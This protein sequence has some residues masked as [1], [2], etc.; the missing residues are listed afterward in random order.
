MTGRV[1]SIDI[2]QLTTKVVE[3]DF[4]AKEPHI[5]AAFQF[6]T[7]EGMLEDGTIKTDD[8]F[9]NRFREE[10]KERKIRTKRVVFTIPSARIAQREITIPAVKDKK[11]ENVLQANAPEYFPVDLKQYQLIHRIMERDPEKKEI[12]LSVVAVPN[13]LLS[14][15]RSLANACG[16]TIADVDYEGHSIFNCMNMEAQGGFAVSLKVDER[17]SILTIIDQD[18]IAQQRTI[19][20]GLGEIIELLQDSGEFG[21]DLSVEKALKILETKRWIHK[22]LDYRVKTPSFLEKM[23]L[24]GDEIGSKDKQEM[25][26]DEATDSLQ[27]LVSNVARALSYYTSK[28]QNAI[29]TG[30]TLMGVGTRCRGLAELLTSE[31]NVPVRPLTEVKGVT[32]ESF[33]NKGEFDLAL[34]VLPIGSAISPMNLTIGKMSFNG[35]EGN[36]EFAST[37]LAAGFCLVCL[38][39][40]AA[41]CL[42]I[43]IQNRNLINEKETLQAQIDSMQEAKVA[44]DNYMATKAK[45]EDIS[46]LK[47]ITST[48]LDQLLKFISNLENKMPGNV[49]VSVMSATPTE[50]VINV[51]TNVKYTAVDV[52]VMLRKCDPLIDFTV[53]SVSE[54]VDENNQ[55]HEEFTVTCIL[56][57]MQEEGNV[58]ANGNPASETNQQSD[59]A[60]STD[61]AGST[62]TAASTDTSAAADTE[63]STDTAG[64]TD[65]GSTAEAGTETSTEAQ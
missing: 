43:K 34:N 62:D 38:I 55:A 61:E 9:V 2:D 8:N 27:M 51:S 32:V 41:L 64:A 14:A 57:G 31:L 48:P 63:G 5:Y 58:D 60:G 28:N 19:S 39:I 46:Q 4:K 25:L 52:L 59:A 47:T 7:P 35:K 16:M 12:K 45:Y 22:T 17:N 44:Y 1:L 36:H 20:Y 42:T 30:I 33:D 23:M 11:I 10:I 50:F 56:K 26:K 29:I 18:N 15:Y 3:I 40:S 24:P 37:N 6:E 54:A 49:Q 13:E 21:D 65:E 53:D